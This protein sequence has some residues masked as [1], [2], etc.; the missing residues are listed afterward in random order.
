MADA[1]VTRNPTTA[2]IRILRPANVAMVALGCAAVRHGLIVPFGAPARSVES[3]WLATGALTLLAAGGN[4]INDYFD[5]REDH[6][7][8]PRLALVGTVISRR[9][10][11]AAHLGTTLIGLGCA[12]LVALREDTPG[13]FLLACAVALALGL[14]SPLFKRGFLR[15]N[16]IIALAVGVLPVWTAWGPDLL[17]PEIAT[18]ITVYAGLSAWVTFLREVVKDLQD[19]EGDA[20]AGYSTLPVVWG[21]NATLRLLT[22]L[23]ALTWIP[24][25]GVA[26]SSGGMKGWCAAFFFPFAGAQW[27]LHTGNIRGTSAWLK[28]TLGG[29]LLAAAFAAA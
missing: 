8:K 2:L 28:A 6:I 1:P 17:R 11:L 25:L 16:V 4:A 24:L 12:A 23:F 26:F 14:Y 9:A 15:G 18:Q 22:I 5:V 20:A 21:P 10:A 3:F 7:N 29:G 19:R 13:F 27:T